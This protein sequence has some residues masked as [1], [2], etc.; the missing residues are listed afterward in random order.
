MIE[1]PVRIR[2]ELF[3][4]TRQVAGG[5]EIRFAEGACRRRECAP[6]DYSSGTR[7]GQLSESRQ[8]G[9]QYWIGDEGWRLPADE[10]NDT[11]RPLRKGC[12]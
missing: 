11:L 3:C 1:K 10:R 2:D 6:L 8:V 7:G 4:G 9:R 5:D 12:K